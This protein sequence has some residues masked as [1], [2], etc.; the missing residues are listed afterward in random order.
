MKERKSD[1]MQEG[2]VSSPSS[3]SDEDE[4]ADE[5]PEAAHTCEVK[6][7]GI[8]KKPS[9][10][11]PSDSSDESSDDS[12]STSSSSEEDEEPAD[13]SSSKTNAYPITDIRRWMR[14]GSIWDYLDSRKPG[15]EDA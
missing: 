8:L 14:P 13:M 5:M 9:P 3:L 15:E 11:E 10:S 7:V 2:A 4:G 12:S 1:L 6:P